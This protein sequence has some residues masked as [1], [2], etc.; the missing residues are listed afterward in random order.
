ML[1][2]LEN[3][4]SS[5][6]PEEI[7][8]L[9]LNQKDTVRYRLDGIKLDPRSGFGGPATW[10]LPPSDSVSPTAASTTLSIL[11]RPDFVLQARR[12]E[13]G[14]RVFDSKD[15][16]KF[17]AEGPGFSLSAPTFSLQGDLVV[18]WEDGRVEVFLRS[19]GW[20]PA[21]FESD[22]RG[23]LFRFSPDGSILAG[24]DKNFR[25]KVW[26]LEGNT[27]SEFQLNAEANE[28]AFDESGELLVCVTRDA[29]VH[30]HSVKSGKPVWSPAELEK[31]ARWVFIQPTGRI[32]TMSDTV[33][34]W[35]RPGA[36]FE[37]SQD[38]Q[39]LNRQVNL[40]TGW[41]YDEI[42]RVRCLTRDEYLRL[43]NE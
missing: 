19:A 16:L 22:F 29:L 38:A 1:L 10:R 11:V 23:E 2:N 30:G 34:V 35:E 18:G 9:N 27:I 5:P 42:G 40:I 37:L 14:F 7:L 13:D 8:R 32:V 24:Q 17:V 33:T 3:G 6:L 31:P 43:A 21:L 28:L 12:T 26:D 20:R 25:V 36:E 4:E 15:Q 39:E 41:T